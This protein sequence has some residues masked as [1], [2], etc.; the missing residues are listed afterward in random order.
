[1]F[2]GPFERK[3]HVPW[4]SFYRDR[5]S[6]F[7]LD[8]FHRNDLVDWDNDLLSWYLEPIWKEK[9][10]SFG[11]RRIKPSFLDQLSTITW[12]WI[13]TWNQRLLSKFPGLKYLEFP[14]LEGHQCRYLRFEPCRLRF[15][16]TDQKLSLFLVQGILPKIIKKRWAF[17]TKSNIS[18]RHF[19]L[20]MNPYF[21]AHLELPSSRQAIL[22]TNSPSNLFFQIWSWPSNKPVLVETIIGASI[23]FSSICG[24]FVC[25]KIFS[26]R[27]WSTRIRELGSWL[28]MDLCG[29]SQSW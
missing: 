5:F 3:G 1:M 28:F 25:W 12:R 29:S 8:L 6:V 23:V 2:K 16:L 26:V 15:E 14:S 4:V 19:V 17:G 22:S 21:A 18:R 24:Q 10:L 11:P 7:R 13:E 20:L 9:N 27:I